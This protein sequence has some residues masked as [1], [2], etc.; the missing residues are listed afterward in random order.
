MATDTLQI[1]GISYSGV[2]GIKATDS[3]NT[4]QTYI[5]PQGTKSITQN[6]TG[7]DVTG[8]AS[9]DV[10]VSSPQSYETGSFT[11][12][13]SGSNY[14]LNLSKTYT[15]YIVFIEADSTSKTTIMNSGITSARSYALIGIFPKTSVGN[16]ESNYQT[17][18]ER[19]NPSSGAMDIGTPSSG[20]T[21]TSSSVTCQT[22]QISSGANY[23]YRGL[24]YNYF[25]TE[26]L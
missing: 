9:V 15:K 17:F 13:D 2:T 25:V 11:C 7:I 20:F 1:F 19:V 14:T 4:V 21:Y 5:R 8:Y 24:T 10:S 18:L 3:N 6:G 12:P 26:I 22:A 16:T 23:L